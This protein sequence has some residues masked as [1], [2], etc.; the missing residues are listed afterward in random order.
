MLSGQVLV[1]RM[2]KSDNVE[3][4]LLQSL[5]SVS[6]KYPIYFNLGSYY[7]SNN[8]YQ[9]AEFYLLKATKSFQPYDTV[10]SL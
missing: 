4:V 5:S 2:G 1:W 8:S 7:L 9:Q 10:G 3:K 6:D